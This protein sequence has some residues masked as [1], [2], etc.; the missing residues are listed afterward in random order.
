MLCSQVRRL[1]EHLPDHPLHVVTDNPDRL[2]LLCPGCLPMTASNA[3]HA[4]TDGTIGLPGPL[5]RALYPVIGRYYHAADHRLRLSSLRLRKTKRY[6]F[7]VTVTGAGI[8]TDSFRSEATALLYWLE[9]AQ[10]ARIPNAIFGQG[11]GPIHSRRLAKRF[12]AAATRTDMLTLREGST[13]PALA[14]SL[15]IPDSLL[16][17]TGDE[18]ID[19]AYDLKPKSLASCLGVNVRMAPYSGVADDIADDLSATIRSLSTDLKCEAIP[20]PISQ[21]PIDSDIPGILKIVGSQ[22]G[23]E[24]H[25]CAASPWTTALQAGRCRL[26]ITGSY[27]A[28]VFALSQGIPVMGLAKSGYYTDKFRGLHHQFGPGMQWCDLS[29]PA[30]QVSLRE[31]A[32]ALWKAADS[33]RDGLLSAARLQIEAT[34]KAYRSFAEIALR[35]RAM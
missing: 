11:L 18:A 5:P 35:R 21:H 31:Q 10:A 19:L 34:D 1:K 9:Y 2:Q 17:V 28:G 7:A 22:Y 30:W 3:I 6:P 20:L 14:K 26:V 25:D 15:G 16:T 23:Q 12:G 32:I 13:G 24:A 8:F 29:V 4:L 27:H 33:L